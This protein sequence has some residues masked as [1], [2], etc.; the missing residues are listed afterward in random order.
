MIKKLWYIISRI[1]IGVGIVL[2]LNYIRY[3]SIAMPVFALTD[4]SVVSY[5]IPYGTTL[6]T[7]SNRF[8][9]NFADGPITLPTFTYDIYDINTSD[10]TYNTFNSFNDIGLGA[11]L[12]FPHGYPE[13]DRGFFVLDMSLNMPNSTSLPLKP[14]NTYTIVLE[15]LKSDNMYYYS[16]LE[17]LL[18]NDNIRLKFFTKNLEE[19]SSL[20]TLGDV[21][22]KS[23]K[24][25]TKDSEYAIISLSFIVNSSVNEN[26]YLERIKFSPSVIDQSESL[27]TDLKPIVFNTGDDNGTFKINT[28]GFIEN[29]KYKTSMQN[30]GSSGGAHSSGG[31]YDPDLYAVYPGNS[32]TCSSWDIV[33][34][35]QTFISDL[36][37]IDITLSDLEYTFPNSPIT[38]IILLPVTLLNKVYDTSSNQCTAYNLGS[39]LGTRLV[40]PCFTL[41]TYLGNDIT[42]IIDSIF[43]IF[44]IYNLLMKIIRY[45]EKW[46]SLDDTFEESTYIN[47]GIF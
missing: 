34:I 29:G 47:T 7:T 44:L 31:G 36:F 43:S 19:T 16:H 20:I 45:V 18:N 35:V 15:L 3:G 10:N 23:G 22:Y 41:S 4:D 21:I 30:Y 32:P 13:N 38:S 25:G 9:T 39:L 28:M 46:T 42:L 27:V 37:S 6:E 40:L 26:L 5:Y 24:R 33:C 11:E 2:L 8:K 17:N 14:G 12:P 1:L